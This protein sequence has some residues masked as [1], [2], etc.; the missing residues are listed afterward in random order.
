MKILER[1][2]GLMVGEVSKYNF[3]FLPRL[4]MSAVPHMLQFN[5]GFLWFRVWL[6]IWSSEMQEFNR[7]S[8][9]TE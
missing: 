6:T 3:D 1:D 8:Y 7:N 5:I 9:D 2:W 4:T